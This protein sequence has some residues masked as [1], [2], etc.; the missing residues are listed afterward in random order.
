ML[1]RAFY[2]RCALTV[3][4]LILRITAALPTFD[5]TLIGGS[6]LHS[7]ELVILAAWA[8]RSVAFDAAVYIFAIFSNG[9][10]LQQNAVIFCGPKLL[11]L[12]LMSMAG[13]AAQS[14]RVAYA[15]SISSV[16]AA[17][18]CLHCECTRK[19]R[20][21]HDHSARIVAQ[22]ECRVASGTLPIVV[23]WAGTSFG[24]CAVFASALFRV[25]MCLACSSLVL[26][27]AAG[28]TLTCT[29]D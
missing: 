7:L 24:P 6:V 21:V 22:C 12:K 14:I 18:A 17:S 15:P 9:D 26:P 8:G 11:E 27:I 4:A 3:L 20:K 28:W 1:P 29:P 5:D 25:A 13:V 23:V 10:V 19:L 2:I 16:A